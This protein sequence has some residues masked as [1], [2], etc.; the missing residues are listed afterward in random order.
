M[1]V[2][3]PAVKY[4]VLKGMKPLEFIEWETTQPYKNEYIAGS[5]YAMAGASISHN[6]I[7]TNIMRK[8]S[9]YLSGKECEIY[10]SDLRIFVKSKE[11]F[12]YPDATIV[13][14][15]IEL[16]EEFKETVKNPSVVFEILSPSTEHYDM[17]KKFF[18][19]MQIDSLRETIA[20]DSREM[21][22]KIGRRKENNL[23]AFEELTHPGELF[24]IDTI[25][26]TMSVQDLYNEVKLQPTPGNDQVASS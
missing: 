25:H 5:I 6:K 18:N 10:A 3:E 4:E 7:L 26:F 9:P 19:Y 23:W 16:A 22:I 13:C 8:I 1:E 24:T 15:E 14:G 17:G 20:I 11:A 2:N 21:N 12:F